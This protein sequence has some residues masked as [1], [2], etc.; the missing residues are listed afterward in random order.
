MTKQEQVIA[1][2]ARECGKMP[3]EVTPETDIESLGMDSLEFLSLLI[4]VR[5]EVGE[6]TDDVAAKLQ[7]VGDLAAAVQA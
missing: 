2:V 6:V 3:E 4:C 7:T 5:D 1:I